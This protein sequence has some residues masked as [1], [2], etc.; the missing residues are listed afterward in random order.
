M[1]KIKFGFS[2]GE[3]L[4]TLGIVGIIAAMTLPVLLE[5]INESK[6][7]S[8]LKSFYSK[9]SVNLDSILTTAGAA[10]GSS[11]C[12]SFD[13]FND[14]TPDTFVSK[15][16][17]NATHCGGCSSLDKVT[18]PAAFNGDI[19]KYSLANGMTMKVMTNPGG[20][21]VGAGANPFQA[22]Y[23]YTDNDGHSHNPDLD[24]CALVFIDV[25]GNSG[26]NNFKNDMFAFY[27]LSG[28]DVKYDEDGIIKTASHRSSPLLPLGLSHDR[29]GDYDSFIGGDGKCNSANEINCTAEVLDG[30][31]NW[32][33]RKNCWVSANG[34]TEEC[35]K[36]E[37]NIAQNPYCYRN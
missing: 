1:K 4:M 8:L 25:N 6:Y 33:L 2:L 5:N 36:C 9:F 3:V 37:K 14:I 31:G 26:P 10:E 11:P 23:Y 28:K 17:F 27:I 29:H 24:V 22:K 34:D 20:C 35:N 30:E 12:D 13:C 15:D 19:A 16:L 21:A 7:R 18:V 32:K